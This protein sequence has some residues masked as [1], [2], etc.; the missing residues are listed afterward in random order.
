MQAG[1]G[2]H[3]HSGPRGLQV[4]V[5]MAGCVPLLASQVIHLIPLLTEMLLT[6]VCV[7]VLEWEQGAVGVRG[8][9]GNGPADS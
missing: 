2:T 3:P 5:I 6:I 9:M 8:V 7:C 4:V 1:A